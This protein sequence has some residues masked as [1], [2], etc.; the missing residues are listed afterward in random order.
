[1]PLL[2]VLLQKLIHPKDAELSDQQAVISLYHCRSRLPTTYANNSTIYSVF[3]M[4]PVVQLVHRHFR[5]NS[6]KTD[7]SRSL[8]QEIRDHIE[9][10]EGSL[11]IGCPQ[12]ASDFGSQRHSIFGAHIQQ[13]GVASGENNVAVAR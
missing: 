9:K 6:L 5:F 2:L 3:A 7:Q 8:T 10:E 4:Y 1:M 11:P 13:R 12:Y